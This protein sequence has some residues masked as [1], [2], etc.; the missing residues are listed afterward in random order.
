MADKFSYDVFLSHNAKDNPRVRRLA[1]R[2]H[3]ANHRRKGLGTDPLAA[4]ERAR[5]PLELFKGNINP[6][7]TASGSVT[8]PVD[9][10][11]DSI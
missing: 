10:M 11:M 9:L 7:A 2:R 6:L 1:E 8:F 5:P 3:Q 4:S